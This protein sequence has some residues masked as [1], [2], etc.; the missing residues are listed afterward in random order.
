[1]AIA[2]KEW[3]LVCDALGSGRQS[4]LLRKGGIAEGRR[5]FGFEHTRF[6]LFPT[7]FHG[8]VE[9][10]RHD[11]AAL[12]EQTPDH[13]SLSYSAEIEWCGRIVDKEA[14]QR[15]SELHVLDGSVIEERFE[16]DGGRG[17]AKGAC[18]EAHGIHVAFV[19]VYRLE[20]SVI[21]PMEKRFGGCRSWV[22]LPEIASG[23]LV[24]VLSDEEHQFRKNRFEELLGVSITE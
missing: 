2:F 20:P 12:P 9:K 22:E 1:M 19:R 4:V 6:Y 18:R 3:A 21:L 7:W 15:L 8:Q 16:Y 13:L 17:V 11:Y 5:G 10:V 23:A 24:S 14:V